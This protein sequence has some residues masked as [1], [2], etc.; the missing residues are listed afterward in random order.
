MKNFLIK[1]YKEILLIIFSCSIVFILTK[2]YS[3]ST[4][5]G[6][7]IKDKLEQLDKNIDEVNQR[8]KE[9]DKQIL[10]YKNEITKIDSTISNIRVEKKTIN[11]YYDK[12]SQDIKNSNDK[13]VDSLFKSR[14][15]Y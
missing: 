14:Y 10:T 7:I 5:N 15:K 2:L 9:L 3:Q 4:D 1:N 6:D 8:Q 12:K 11:N 13:Q